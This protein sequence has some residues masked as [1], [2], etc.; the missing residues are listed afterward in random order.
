MENI[1]MTDRY[2]PEK[3]RFKSSF[4][5]NNHHQGKNMI[6]RNET[7]FTLRNGSANRC[8]R[9]AGAFL[10]TDVPNINSKKFK[11]L[12]L[13]YCKKNRPSSAKPGVRPD[14]LELQAW[15]EKKN[16]KTSSK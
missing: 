2:E 16:L 1:K 10:T 11:V 6:P 13:C 5:K 7:E 4:K 8:D 14:H 12:A 15:P 9:V 3:F